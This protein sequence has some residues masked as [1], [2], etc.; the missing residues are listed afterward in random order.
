MHAFFSAAIILNL[1]LSIISSS[2][3]AFW[4]FPILTFQHFLIPDSFLRLPIPSPPTR[5]CFIS[6]S[7]ASSMCA[8]SLGK[9]EGINN[10]RKQ[11]TCFLPSSHVVKCADINGNGRG[12]SRMKLNGLDRGREKHRSTQQ[13]SSYPLC[14]SRWINRWWWLRS[15]E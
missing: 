9:D 8:D 7:L 12:S 5:P 1:F 3:H 15:S 2:P 14:C 10:I 11:S 4:P 6:P 13:L